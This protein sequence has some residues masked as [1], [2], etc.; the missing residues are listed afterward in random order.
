MSTTSTTKLSTTAGEN[1]MF[2]AVIQRTCI[3]PTMSAGVSANLD[4]NMTPL[5][6]DVC[7]PILDNFTMFTR[8]FA[9]A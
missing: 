1:T 3:T 9:P 6:K 5:Q 8:R 7:A 4:S 2:G